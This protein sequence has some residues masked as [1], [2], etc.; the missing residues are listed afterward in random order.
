MWW[1]KSYMRRH[2][3]GIL[4]FLLFGGICT[5]VL[6]LYH[7]PMEAI[8]YALVLCLVIGGIAVLVDASAYRKKVQKLLEQQEA[9]KNGTEELPNAADS[10]EEAYQELIYL[11]QEERRER[12]AKLMREKRDITD[13]F[14]LW[15]H[16]IKTPIAAMR[17][18]FQQETENI[19]QF[20]EQRKE[21]EGELFKIEQYVEMVLQYLRLNS[22]VNDFVLQEY[23][24]DSIIRQA[25]HKYAP[26]F[27][28]KKLALH[29][30]TI[31][32]KVV[33]DEKWMVFVVEQILSNAIKYTVEGSISIY[34]EGGNLV[35]ADTGIGILP[36]DLPRVFEKGYTGYNG[37]NDKKASGIGLYLCKQILE[38]L[39]HKVYV[40]SE[41]GKGT[42]M[43]LVF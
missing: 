10:L 43:K 33:T 27:I 1:I 34:M 31:T 22:S 11:A 21:C 37:R 23:S 16:Q 7:L 4:L 38:K 35:I 12:T 30:E 8:G 24:L 15:A 25:I 40:T 6:F 3:L 2:R 28:R 9:V 14:T 29:Y 36:E 5:A 26:M 17:L 32:T 41:P 20:Y 13:Y 19:E 42:K 18:L 39:G